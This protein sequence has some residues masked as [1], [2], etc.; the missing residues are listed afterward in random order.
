[1]GT[2]AIG[3]CIRFST[4]PPLDAAPYDASTDV[5]G[6]TVVSPEA[7]PETDATDGSLDDGDAPG[8]AADAT[9]DAAPICQRF[10]PIIAQAIAGDLVSAL[11]Q[12][13]KI[14]SAFTPLPPVRLQHFQECSAA[15]V[16]SVLGCLQ[17]DGTRYKYPAYDSHGQFCRDMKTAHAGLNSS[18]GDFDAFLAA[19]RL[20]LGKNG[21]TDDEIVRTMRTFNA[22]VT[23]SD[24]VKR[25]DAGPTQPC[26]AAAEAPPDMA[27]DG[28]R[29]ASAD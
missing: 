17:A 22:S 19:L 20:A 10:D 16:A 6:D 24:I 27:R 4:E 1:M 12:D 13:C 29:D 5:S 7:G 2:L 8:R 14:Q 25:K 18:D 3:G 9:V 15:L 21:L 26:D 28:G 23:R 11:L